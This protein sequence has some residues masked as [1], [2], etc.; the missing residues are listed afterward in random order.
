MK[1]DMVVVTKVIDPGA[2]FLLQDFSAQMSNSLTQH[3]KG[4]FGDE[5]SQRITWLASLQ[6]P[7]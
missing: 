3:T 1:Q 6:H 2:Q 5:S 7:R 4:H